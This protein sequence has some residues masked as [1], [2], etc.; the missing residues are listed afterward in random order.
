MIE[1]CEEFIGSLYFIDLEEYERA[2]RCLLMT[3]VPYKNVADGL[4]RAF[5]NREMERKKL[6]SYG[7]F[8]EGILWYLKNMLDITEK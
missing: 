3:T 1:N 6:L 7:F 2:W 8:Q 5:E 4:L